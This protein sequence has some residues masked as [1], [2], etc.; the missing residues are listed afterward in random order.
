M[1]FGDYIKPKYGETSKLYVIWT[2]SFIE[3]IKTEAIYKDIS[4]DVEKRF[5]T[6][7]Y[8]VD[9]LLPIGKNKKVLRLMKDELGRQIM[10]KNCWIML[11]NIELIKR[12]Q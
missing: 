11:K 8:E 12:Q 6:S 1:I 4:Q 9:R 3:H 10:K 7:N 2:Q 5:D